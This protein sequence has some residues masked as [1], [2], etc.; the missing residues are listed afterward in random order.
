MLFETV[1]GQIVKRVLELVMHQRNY[2]LML[3]ARQEDTERRREKDMI[4]PVSGST[5]PKINALPSSILNSTKCFNFASLV[6]FA[7]KYS[8]LE[9]NATS[10]EKNSE[11]IIVLARVVYICALK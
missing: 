1:M 8:V 5:I 10:N 6:D 7:Q 9:K 3:F 2:K 11:E 4:T